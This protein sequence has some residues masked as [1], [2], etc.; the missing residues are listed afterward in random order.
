MSHQGVD[1]K[2]ID[3]S[4]TQLDAGYARLIGFECKTTKGFEWFG[5][6]P[7]HDAL[8]AYGLLEFTDMAIVRDV[9]KAML[10]RTRDFVMSS[11]DGNGGYKRQTHTLHTWVADPECAASYNTW[12]LLEAGADTKQLDK[13]IAWIRENIAKSNNTYALALATNILALAGDK[14]AADAFMKKLAAKQTDTGLVDGATTSVIGSGGEALQI[15]TT[16]LATL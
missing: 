14:T 13:E 10:A 9:D 3:R 11:R 7:G 15:E 12:A 5:A 6:D 2:L 8:S 4:R 16:S 1:P